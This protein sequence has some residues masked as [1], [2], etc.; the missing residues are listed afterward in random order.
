MYP[1]LLRRIASKDEESL[2]HGSYRLNQ[3]LIPLF[4]FYSRTLAPED[5]SES[6]L[7]PG[8]VLREFLIGIDAESLAKGLRRFIKNLRFVLFVHNQTLPF[9]GGAKIIESSRPVL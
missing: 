7:G 2:A 5:E 3:K 4:S 8:P 1:I 6:H 9:Q